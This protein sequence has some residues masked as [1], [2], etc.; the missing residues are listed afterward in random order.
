MKRTLE[1]WMSQ[2]S[3]S[4]KFSYLKLPNTPKII[5]S[6]NSLDCSVACAQLRET[7]TYPAVIGFDTEWVPSRKKNHENKTSVIQI[8]TQPNKQ[9]YVFQISEMNGIPN[10]LMEIIEDINVTK[11]GV[12]IEND[13]SKL[14]QD[15]N[16]D[17]ISLGK[18]HID[19]SNMA[20]SL[21]ISC[22]KN[23]SL[24]RLTETLLE[25]TIQKSKSLQLSNWEDFPLSDSQLQYAALDAYAS[26]ILYEELIRRTYA[27]DKR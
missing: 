15:F 23:W 12:G 14:Y 2:A 22:Q 18:S 26:L 9:C 19:L 13:L 7:L 11:T 21:S 1:K 25:K 24:R 3:K 8:C 6:H 17:Q 5:Y 20:K 27:K 4:I 10:K 16:I